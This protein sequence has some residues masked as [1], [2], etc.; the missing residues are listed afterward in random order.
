MKKTRLGNFLIYWGISIPFCGVYSTIQYKTKTFK[1]YKEIF[2][3]FS[4]HNI[5]IWGVIMYVSLVVAALSIVLGVRL[6]KKS[7]TP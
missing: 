5:D 6:R 1:S 7:N 2:F 4:K 3:N